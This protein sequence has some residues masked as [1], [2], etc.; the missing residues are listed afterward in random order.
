MC[1]SATASFG[2]AA[3]LGAIGA[4]SLTKT[5]KSTQKM[6]AAIPLVF[7]IQQAC[8][9]LLWLA[10]KQ[11]SFEPWQLSATYG[12]LFFAQIL[13]P[14]WIPVSI[15]LLEHDKN[16]KRWLQWS[17]IGGVICSLIMI[18]RIVNFNVYAE[19]QNHHILYHVNDSMVLI[20]ISSLF[21]FI[22]TVCA[23]FLSSVPQMK[24]FG[25]FS[26]GSL[27]ITKICYK[28]YFISVW[29]FFAAIL[30]LVVIYILKN[31]HDRE[32]SKNYI[33]SDSIR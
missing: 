25:I 5:K 7:A 1:F 24:L 13:W 17:S 14:T 31:I 15:F 19:I 8:E 6:F 20:A 29:C 18:Y 4:V 27:V 32:S 28:M 2:A 11:N 3:V 16:R 9:G 10:L 12:F 23:A 26:L 22:S 30:S 33:N 21:Y